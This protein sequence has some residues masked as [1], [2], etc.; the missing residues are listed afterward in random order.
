MASSLPHRPVIAAS[1][2]RVRSTGLEHD[3]RPDPILSDVDSADP[4]LDAARPVLQRA[5]EMLDGTPTALLLVD[6]A[7]R[8]VARVSGDGTLERRLADA[9]V[10]TG[11]DFTEAAMGTTALGT[12]AEVRGDTVI[13]SSEH[14]LEQFRS[15]SCF[16]RPIIHPGTR[17][18]AGILCM[19]EE[20]QRINPLSLPLVR[21]IAH[22]IGER[23]LTRSHSDHQRVI[24]AFGD[25]ADRRDIA[26]AALGD[27]LQ[28]TNALAAQLLA[29]ADFGTLRLLLEQNDIPPTVTLV[30]G[31]TAAVEADRIPGVR[32]AAIF[33][34]RP[35]ID[36]LPSGGVAAGTPT[37]TTVAIC[38][39]PGT[40]RTTRA[41]GIAP[42]ERSTVVDVAA[43]LLAGTP[44][45]LAATLR[46]AQARGEGVVIDAAD[47]LDERSLQLLL[48]AV[49]GRSAADPALV[50]VTGPPDSLSPSA[51]ALVARCRR[52]TTLPPLRQR[53]TELAALGQEILRARDVRLTLSTDASDALVSQEWPGNLREFATVLSEAADAARARGARTVDVAD[54]PDGYRS[55]SRVSRLLGL[56]QAERLAI[57]EALDAA[58]GNKSHA[59]KRLGISRT[60]LYAR[61]RALGIR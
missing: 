33:R 61:I 11:A 54:L 14:Y 2:Q 26:L 8:M 28:L 51:S 43:T 56:E 10:V 21:G 37:A 58:S 50:V 15:L 48:A 6:N 55:T 35:R 12:T 47:L 57:V 23:L 46:E 24:A 45:D 40:G 42:R 13:N 5:A 44:L 17:R 27:N 29:P 32:H 4:L 34:L 41:F 7:S 36:R 31:V 1:W 39:E 49:A 20:A 52:R 18:V 16:G 25:A 30:S 60:T 38:G 59:A 9:G 53:P 22:D 3:H 19:T